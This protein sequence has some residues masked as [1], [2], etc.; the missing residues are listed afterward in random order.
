MS[1]IFNW[2]KRAELE[3]G[4][5]K[6]EPS[7][8]PAF[9]IPTDSNGGTA[10]PIPNEPPDRDYESEPMASNPFPSQV[11]MHSTAALNL[12]SADY[13]VRDVWD[14]V[15]NVGEQF[16][17][18][19]AR[20]AL[21]QKQRSIKTL[22]VTSAAPGEG[23]T[24]VSCGLS[25][26]LAQEPGKRVLL[27]D[28]DL[29]KPMAAQDL[30]LNTNTD[31]QGFSDV[32]NGK[33]EVTDVLLSS[34]DSRFFFLPAGKRTAN[35][36]EL[37]SSSLLPRALKLLSERFNWIVIDSPPAIALADTNVIAQVCDAVLLVVHSNRT[38]SKLIKDCIQRIGREKICGVVMNRSKHLKNSRYYSYY[39]PSIGKENEQ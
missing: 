2:L 25:G 7:I 19:R 32:L 20:L 8:S 21:M 3:K 11:E 36:A 9:V 27:I 39:Q 24:F 31:R 22:L 4:N 16:R 34:A 29:R 28:G 37:L 30:G 10:A 35:P 12:D 33:V 15:T 38:S 17:L 23:K 14:P 26:V 1:E 6:L 5:F 18:L 13:R